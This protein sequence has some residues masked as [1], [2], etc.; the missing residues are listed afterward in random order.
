[1]TP[2]ELKGI[3]A[4]QPAHEFVEREILTRCPWIF[5]AEQ[6]Y[7]AW[8]GAVA[9]ELAADPRSIRIVGS[10]ATGYS[11]SP[12]K[13]GRPFRRLSSLGTRSSDIDVAFLDADLFREAWDTIVL[14]D[15]QR[16]LGVA[17]DIRTKI[18][19]DVYW[20]AIGQHSLP[21]NTDTARRFL[22]ALSILSRRPPLR[23]YQVRCRVYRRIDDLR[24]YH[25]DSLRQLRVQLET[26]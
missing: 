6:D 8:L 21:R 7:Q 23:G 24:A 20:G 26:T 16:R 22:T 4:N 19:L 13:P 5:D 14:F 2:A 25:I 12:L 10:A 9:A 15:R 18:R 11:L 3:L 1:M 17:L